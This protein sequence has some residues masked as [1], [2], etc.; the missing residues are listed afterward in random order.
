MGIL[1]VMFFWLSEDEWVEQ[2]NQER[3]EQ[4]HQDSWVS[5]IHAILQTEATTIFSETHCQLSSHEVSEKASKCNSELALEN[6]ALLSKIETLKQELESSR[7][8]CRS[9][10]APH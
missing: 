7:L 8:K 5:G 3:G 4:S 2:S 10:E 1:K 9:R 6:A